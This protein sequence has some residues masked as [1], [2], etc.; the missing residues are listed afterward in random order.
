[1]RESLPL[2][3]F[4]VDFGISLIIFHFKNLLVNVLFPN[5]GENM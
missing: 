2:T 3:Q 4:M 1:M 5:F